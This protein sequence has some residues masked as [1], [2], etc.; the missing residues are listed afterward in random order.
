MSSPL[1]NHLFPHP[2]NVNSYE[3]PD[4][5]APTATGGGDQL[6]T[7]TQSEIDNIVDGFKDLTSSSS[8]S[9]NT[10]NDVS[11]IKKS[12]SSSLR[13]SAV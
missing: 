6:K 9:L 4:P 13:Q 8:S 5:T 1:P 2:Q 11:D 3:L 10:E 12:S 7:K